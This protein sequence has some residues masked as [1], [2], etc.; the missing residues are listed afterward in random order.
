MGS[1]FPLFRERLA[2]PAAPMTETKVCSRNKTRV[3]SCLG[4][5]LP[6]LTHFPRCGQT[7]CSPCF[8]YAFERIATI[9]KHLGIDRKQVA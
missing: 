8:D 9:E 1:D 7:K 3:R 5:P 4:G 2:W 6:N